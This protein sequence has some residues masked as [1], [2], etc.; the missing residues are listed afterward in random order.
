LQ[1]FISIACSKAQTMMFASWFR[2]EKDVPNQQIPLLGQGGN[3]L[4]LPFDRRALQE[5]RHV[6]QRPLTNPFRSPS[7]VTDKLL[8]VYFTF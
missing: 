3:S 1:G 7:P 2:V 4:G 6:G 5:H 8:F